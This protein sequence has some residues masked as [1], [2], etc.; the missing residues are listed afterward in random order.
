MVSRDRTCAGSAMMT[1]AFWLMSAATIASRLLTAAV[2][3]PNG[4]V[5]CTPCPT[6]A[7]TSASC[8]ASLWRR[9]ITRAFSCLMVAGLS[10]ECA[11]VFKRMRTDS[12]PIT[13]R[14]LELLSAMTC[15]PPAF[16]LS[17]VFSMTAAMS[18]ARPWRNSMTECPNCPPASSWRANWTIRWVLAAVSVTTS[19]LAEVE[20]PT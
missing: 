20:G 15:P 12:V 1:N 2:A 14:R 17:I 19:A 4:A 13:T 9:R 5:S 18:L 16:F 6:A 8:L 3:P 11:K 10:S 7:S